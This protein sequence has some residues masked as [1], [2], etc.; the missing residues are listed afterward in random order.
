MIPK[1][2][3][4][5]VPDFSFPVAGKRLD[6]L[7]MPTVGQVWRHRDTGTEY[8]IDRIEPTGAHFCGS[9]GFLYTYAEMAR[10]LEFAS[11]PNSERVEPTVGSRWM[12]ASGLTV[13]LR[14]YDANLQ[15]WFATWQDDAGREYFHWYDAGNFATMLPLL[16]KEPAHR[17]LDRGF[18]QALDNL[19]EDLGTGMSPTVADKNSLR[20]LPT[21]MFSNL[22]AF[23]EHWSRELRRCECG[24]WSDCRVGV[25]EHFSESDPGYTLYQW[26]HNARLANLVLASPP[27]HALDGFG[28]KRGPAWDAFQVRLA[29]LVERREFLRRKDCV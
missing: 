5:P 29:G 13:Q 12:L 14:S 20:N 11:G 3:F 17:E 26:E 25:L 2:T 7:P 6:Y 24:P 9:C 27:R 22:R 18:K 8:A 4:A 19:N 10:E 21:Y 1:L 15:Q 23:H 16:P 28:Y